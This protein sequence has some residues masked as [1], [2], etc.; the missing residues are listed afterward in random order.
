MFFLIIFPVLTE[1]VF[2]SKSLPSILKVH[3]EFNFPPHWYNC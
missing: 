3:I 1:D 2:L